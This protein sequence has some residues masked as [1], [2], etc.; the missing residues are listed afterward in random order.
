MFQIASQKKYK[1]TIRSALPVIPLVVLSVTTYRADS[2]SLSLSMDNT[3][4]HAADH[5]NKTK[6]LDNQLTPKMTGDFHLFQTVVE[7]TAAL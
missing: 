3:Y 4:E 6:K 2:A 7:L 1:S 5:V